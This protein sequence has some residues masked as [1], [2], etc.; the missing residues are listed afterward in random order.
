V[1][2]L[3]R[4]VRDGT[5]LIRFKAYDMHQDTRKMASLAGARLINTNVLPY[6]E[7]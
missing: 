7:I 3:E 2:A 6:R 4:A 1:H 5:R